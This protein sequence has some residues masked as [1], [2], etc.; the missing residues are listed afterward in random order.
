MGTQRKFILTERL[1][2]K[3]DDLTHARAIDNNS[4]IA[5][6]CLIAGTSLQTVA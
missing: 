6:G 1:T 4:A 2:A 3:A 5:D